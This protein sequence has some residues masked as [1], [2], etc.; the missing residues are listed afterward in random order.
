MFYRIELTTQ[1]TNL[2]HVDNPQQEAYKMI[3]YIR[4]VLGCRYRLI[5]DNSRYIVKGEGLMTITFVKA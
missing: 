5:E 1:P 2:V 4:N 3:A